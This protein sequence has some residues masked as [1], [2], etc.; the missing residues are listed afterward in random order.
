MIEIIS[1]LLICLFIDFL[2]IYADEIVQSLC[3]TL[4]QPFNNL[5]QPFD[6]LRVTLLKVTL[7]RVTMLRVTLLR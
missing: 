1:D 2:N 4:R 6:K 7:L 3:I 5:R